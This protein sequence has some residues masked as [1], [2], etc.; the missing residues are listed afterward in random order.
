MRFTQEQTDAL[1][2]FLY[3]STEVT[4]AINTP[5]GK[6][7]ELATEL[8]VTSKRIGQWITNRK[9][10]FKPDLFK[11]V[12]F[13]ACGIPGLQGG[14]RTPAVPKPRRRKKR[15]GHNAVKAE[16]GMPKLL[17]FNDSGM[18]ILEPQNTAES[19]LHELWQPCNGEPPA[20]KIKTENPPLAASSTWQ[21]EKYPS[22]PNTTVKSEMKG[23]VTDDFR[24][25]GFSMGLTTVEPSGGL[26]TPLIPESV[27]FN[28]G[29]VSNSAM[30]IRGFAG[31]S[32][33]VPSAL[34]F[35]SFL[36]GLP[37]ATPNTPKTPLPSFKAPLNRPPPFV[38][39][40]DETRDFGFVQQ[41]S[42]KREPGT[43][44]PKTK[45]KASPAIRAATGSSRKKFTDNQQYILESFYTANLFT[46]KEIKEKVA[47]STGLS[48]K[49]VRVWIMNRKVRD[50]KGLPPLIPKIPSS[51]ARGFSEIQRRQL[52][53]FFQVGLLDQSNYREAISKATGLS[54]KQIRVWRMNT[55]AKL[56]KEGKLHC[57]EA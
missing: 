2:K 26:Q 57:S 55:R 13:Q 22:Q 34:L 4:V 12:T 11:K 14:V 49:Q 8:N 31:S 27:P 28:S 18:P 46:S 15:N 5:R 48:Y 56:K 9:R 21:Y 19:S 30:D 17:N 44:L 51:S 50:K 7:T 6:I 35:P 20:K 42:V 47:L 32:I 45:P 29:V 24:R 38:G 3:D 39:A 33:Q 54:E 36:R 41:K 1:W 52:T 37:S 23:K 16:R 25:S 43:V 40:A 53:A 10:T